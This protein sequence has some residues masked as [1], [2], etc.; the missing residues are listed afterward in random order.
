MQTRYGHVSRFAASEGSFVKAG[1]I[2]GYTGGMPGTKGAGYL[3]TGPHLHFE[4][5][6][7][8]ETTDDAGDTYTVW[9]A[10]NPLNYLP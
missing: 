3:T 4:V 8:S 10:V 6:I 5:R 1:Q 2:V 9:Q 7:G